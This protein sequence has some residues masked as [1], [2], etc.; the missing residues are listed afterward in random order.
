[1]VIAMRLCGSMKT[2]KYSYKVGDR[3]LLK[4]I[5]KIPK[6]SQSWP[7]VNKFFGKWVTIGSIPD[8]HY[9]FHIQED[10]ENW[11]FNWEWVV[12]MTEEERLQS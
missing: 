11:F 12:D 5:S 3:V 6:S 9:H 7:E 8:G 1:M 4:D 10:S 2:D